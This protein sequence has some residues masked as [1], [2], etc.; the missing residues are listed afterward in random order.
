MRRG[1]EGNYCLGSL[2]HYYE[3]QREVKQRTPL[4]LDKRRKC[5]KLFVF[6][7]LLHIEQRMSAIHTVWHITHF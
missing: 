4:H 1:P 5:H 7:S 3:E 6:V 2:T